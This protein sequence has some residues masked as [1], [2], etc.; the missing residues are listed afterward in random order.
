MKSFPRCK[1]HRGVDLKE[2]TLKNF[3]FIFIMLY[4][5][6]LKFW[7]IFSRIIPL[8]AVVHF[9]CLAMASAGYLTTPNGDSA[10]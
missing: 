3:K 8:R 7:S 10:V 4:G 1:I 6:K 5:K 9:I 2:H